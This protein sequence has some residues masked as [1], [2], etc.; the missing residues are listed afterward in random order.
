MIMRDV[1]DVVIPIALLLIA[2]AIAGLV[3]FMW[4]AA[5]TGKLHCT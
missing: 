3:A 1:E 5:L 2:L 4:Y